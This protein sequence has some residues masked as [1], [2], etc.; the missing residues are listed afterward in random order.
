MFHMKHMLY[1]IAIWNIFAFFIMGIDKHR[2]KANAQRISEKTLITIAFAMGAA[3]ACTGAAF[4]HHKTRKAKFRIL[5]PTA[6]IFNI[7]I[8]CMIV[9]QFA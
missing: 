6:F 9:Y 8:I 3:G 2:A 7:I 4:F 1:I 5:L